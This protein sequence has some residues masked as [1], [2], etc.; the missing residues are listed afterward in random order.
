M[1]G[2]IAMSLKTVP[3]ILNG[4]LVSGGLWEYCQCRGEGEKTSLYLLD[5]KYYVYLFFFLF[6]IVFWGAGGT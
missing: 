3:E 6:K 1:K 2:K 5:Q 4:K